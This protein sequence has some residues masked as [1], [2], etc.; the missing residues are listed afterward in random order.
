MTHFIFN[1]TNIRGKKFRTKRYHFE[2]FVSLLKGEVR[3]CTGGGDGWGLD[4]EESPG[5]RRNEK[6]LCRLRDRRV[7]PACWEKV[8]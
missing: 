3:H 5:R 6:G 1:K 2:V 8:S 7:C 4:C